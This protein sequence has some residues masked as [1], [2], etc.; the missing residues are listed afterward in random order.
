MNT[1]EIRQYINRLI[2]SMKQPMEQ[3]ED[4]E[5]AK[6]KFLSSRLSWSNQA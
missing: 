5:T 3:P 1:V 4:K 6:A 2:R